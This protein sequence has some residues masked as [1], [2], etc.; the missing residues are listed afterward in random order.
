[1]LY[2]FLSSQSLIKFFSESPQRT[3]LEMSFSFIFPL[4][5][6]FLLLEK[7]EQIDVNDIWLRM[8]CNDGRRLT[9]APCE[10]W[11]LS[12]ILETMQNLRFPEMPA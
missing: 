6:K 1:M 11:F 5:L 8:Q 9:A 3:V 4:T 12:N 2:F 10:S 7:S